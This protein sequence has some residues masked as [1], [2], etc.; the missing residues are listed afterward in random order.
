[1]NMCPGVWVMRRERGPAV[2]EVG[3]HPRQGER[4]APSAAGLDRAGADEVAEFAEV[5]RSPAPTVVA[6]VTTCP[7]RVP[8]GTRCCV[9]GWGWTFRR[10]TSTPP[11]CR[12]STKAT[13]TTPVT[14]PSTPGGGRS[15]RRERIWSTSSERTPRRGASAAQTYRASVLL[16]RSARRIL[17]LCGPGRCALEAG[18]PRPMTCPSVW[19]NLHRTV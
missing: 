13:Y 5:G 15:S 19:A 7:T 14:R 18:I 4:P 17:V 2:D 12:T 16:T 3:Q 9:T 6:G 10:V 1:M 11:G 8:T